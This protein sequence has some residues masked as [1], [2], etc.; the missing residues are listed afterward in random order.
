MSEKPLALSKH[1]HE[2][3][4]RRGIDRATVLD[5]AAAPEQIVPVRPG[6]EIR[7]SRREDQLRKSFLV[8]VVVD[9][10]AEVDIVITVYRTSKLDKYWRAP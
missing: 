4:A 3:A 7:Q 6:R 10:R 5:V 2:R 9:T 1:A 8:R